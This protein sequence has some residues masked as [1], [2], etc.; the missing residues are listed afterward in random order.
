MASLSKRK[1]GSRFIQF[2]DDNGKRQTIVL[3]KMAKRQAESIRSNIEHLIACNA[4][5]LAIDAQVAN[6]I[7]SLTGPL[8]ERIA[9]AGLIEERPTYALAA[10][11]AEYLRRR[12][13]LKP[14]TRYK[15][16]LCGRRL[17]EFFG[18]TK[19]IDQVTQPEAVDC[20]RWLLEQLGSNTARR[21]AG[22]AKQF[23]GD[24][25]ERKLITENPFKS[26]NI[27]TQV[28]PNPAKFHYVDRE[29]IT[30]VLNA[31]PTHEW[32]AIVALARYGGLRCPSEL[33]PLQ[34]EDIDWQ[35]SKITITSPKTAHHEGKESRQCPLFQEL[36]EELAMWRKVSGNTSGPVITRYRNANQNLGTTLKR[37]V[38]K[39]G[40]DPWPKLFQNMRS[41]RETELVED[42]HPVHVVCNWLGNSELIAAK[43]YLQTTDDHFQR[44][45]MRCTDPETIAA[46][47]L[48]Q[49]PYQKKKTRKTSVS[50]STGVS[51][52]PRR[53]LEPP[54]EINPTRT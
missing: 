42:G 31:C 16:K 21:E 47:A 30:K 35:K 14:S 23:F 22:R 13:D 3:G 11:V 46:Q 52:M 33:I 32:R 25:V 8:R 54:R 34:W 6:W 24:A 41:T 19:Q 53:G 5:G 29:T 20:F 10:F 1:N 2:T 48:R 37:F 50:A 18:D 51:L 4:G 40:V 43:F 15:L 45:A 26:K 36:A 7:G 44:A 28:Q 38:L 39:A 27:P 12:T 9:K 17:C 49:L